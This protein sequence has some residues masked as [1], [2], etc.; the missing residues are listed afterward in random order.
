MEPSSKAKTDKA[1]EMLE[2]KEKDNG[3]GKAQSKCG[4]DG[5]EKS[6]EIDKKTYPMCGKKYKG[7]CWKKK[8]TSG[9][10][11]FN[12]K[13]KAKN[14]HQTNDSKAI[15]VFYNGDQFGF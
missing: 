1:R 6:T 10:Q 3:G 13:Q 15:K 11:P 7:K 9:K 14:L 12:K 8:G 4:C 2:L 5:N